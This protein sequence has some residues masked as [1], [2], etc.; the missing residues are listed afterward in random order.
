MEDPIKDCPN[1]QPNH[2]TTEFNNNNTRSNIKLES[3]F[4]N[5]LITCN[6]SSFKAFPVIA[7]YKAINSLKDLVGSKSFP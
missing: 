7:N 6:V 3:L 2:N 5:L 1:L 4:I